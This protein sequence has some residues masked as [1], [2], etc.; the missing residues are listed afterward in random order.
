L[1]PG[2][3]LICVGCGEPM[4]PRG[5]VIRRQ[6]LSCTREF[7]PTRIDAKFCADA[8]RFRAYRARKAA[9][10]EE[11]RREAERRKRSADWVASLIA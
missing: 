1:E 11:A 4:A 2:E 6:C 10:A 5:R 7:F 9:R 3:M 8:C